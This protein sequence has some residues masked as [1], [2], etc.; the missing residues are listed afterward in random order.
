VDYAVP[1]SP[2]WWMAR[3]WLRFLTGLVVL[4]IALG[5]SQAGVD[6][7]RRG[8]PVEAVPAA[9]VQ[10]AAVQVAPVSPA[11]V[12]TVSTVSASEPDLVVVAGSPPVVP[13]RPAWVR[14]VSSASVEVVAVGERAPPAAASAR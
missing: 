14:I 5:V 8:Q 9:A 10:V 11:T 6:E 1:T 3:Q 4:A 13:Q 7:R 2:L 12:S